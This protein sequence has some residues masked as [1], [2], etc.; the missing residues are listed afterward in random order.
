MNSFDSIFADAEVQSDGET[1]L[2]DGHQ[3]PEKQRR[4]IIEERSA[5]SDCLFGALT[6]EDEADDASDDDD[7]DEDFDSE[8]QTDGNSKVHFF[9]WQKDLINPLVGIF[10][11]E[12]GT[13][14]IKISHLLQICH[15]GFHLLS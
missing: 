3:P 4:T 7:C 1:E 11:L 10:S 14:P 8:N 2:N 15:Y 9:C 13:P 12:D 6:S 5:E